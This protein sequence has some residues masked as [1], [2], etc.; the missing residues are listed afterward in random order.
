[1]QH[2]HLVGWLFLLA[3]LA[4][5]LSAQDYALTGAR[6]PGSHPRIPFW[7]SED[8]LGAVP[9]DASFGHGLRAI[10][11]AAEVWNVQGNSNARLDFRGPT[12]LNEVKDDGINVVLFADG[13]CP[14]AADGLAAAF[15][16]RRGAYIHGFD[17][18]LYR[19]GEGRYRNFWSAK[20]YLN[21]WE[22]DITA[23][24]VHEFGHILGLDPL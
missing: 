11:N 21:P 17:I 2:R 1:M 22:S 19:G 15:V 16:H 12:T 24:M 8:L 6:W 10:L 7:V 20:N 5:R 4:P 18:V 23:I 14:F 9:Y 13:P 3:L